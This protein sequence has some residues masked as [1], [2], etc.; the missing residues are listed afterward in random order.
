MLISAF[1]E[2]YGLLKETSTI[3][4]IASQSSL[5]LNLATASDVLKVTRTPKPEDLIGIS[6]AVAA[7]VTQFSFRKCLMLMLDCASAAA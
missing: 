1:A 7:K 5:L 3:D 4:S 6:T 2:S